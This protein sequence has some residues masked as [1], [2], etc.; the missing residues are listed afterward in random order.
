MSWTSPRPAAS[1]PSAPPITRMAR[2]TSSNERWF[3]HSTA[4]PAPI[5]SRTTSFWR[6]ENARTRSG[7][8]ARI[9]SVRNVVK[10]PTRA[11]SR[12]ASGRRAV[13]GTPITRSPAPR[14]KAISAVSAVRQTM[15]WGKST[16]VLPYI[17]RSADAGGLQR[18]GEVALLQPAGKLLDER[19]G[20]LQLDAAGSHAVGE[21]EV[22][23]VDAGQGPD[24]RAQHEVHVEAGIL[25]ADV[26][27]GALQDE[28]GGAD[29]CVK[30]PGF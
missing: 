8:S 18:L 28:P 20:P 25:H 30:D 24:V 3:V 11:F 2:S 21:A 17:R 23:G 1:Q 29:V 14:V 26:R 9:L 13:P 16:A 27:A 15:R 7:S 19:A 6:S 10:P 22:T 5:R 12:A 4:T